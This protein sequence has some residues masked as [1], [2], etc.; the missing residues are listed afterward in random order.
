MYRVVMSSWKQTEEGAQSAS[1]RGRPGALQ[2]CP[3]QT[4]RG[5]V[6]S[7]RRPAPTI[8]RKFHVKSQR[9]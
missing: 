8:N 2:M 5:G 4:S 9:V 1:A 3:G 6:G 7:C